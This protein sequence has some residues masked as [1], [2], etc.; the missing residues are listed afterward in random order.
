M[1]RFELITNKGYFLI[2]DNLT[3]KSYDCNTAKGR[4]ELLD[5]LNSL[6]S[7]S[8]PYGYDDE[9][10]GPYHKDDGDAYLY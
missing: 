3:G 5:L 6:D 1:S 9:L 10:K 2:N 4:I 8:E 7:E